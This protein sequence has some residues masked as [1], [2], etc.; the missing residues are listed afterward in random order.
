MIRST[1][2][3]QFISEQKE[4]RSIQS[5]ELADRIGISKGYGAIADLFEFINE[6]TADLFS[7]D[8]VNSSNDLE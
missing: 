8:W 4:K 3:G 2:F 6:S 1:D 5:Q 7:L